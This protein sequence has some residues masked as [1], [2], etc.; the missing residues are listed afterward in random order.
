[1]CRSGVGGFR[2]TR[3]SRYHTLPELGGIMRRREFIAALCGATAMPLVARAQRPA[4]LQK[5]GFL[6]DES[7]SLG[8]AAAEL[9]AK[10]LH[11]LG[12][13]EGHNIAFESRYADGKNDAL[14]GLAAE[15]VRS[16]VN[17]MVA[18]GTPATR[19]A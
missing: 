9:I 5:V 4:A 14:A 12:Y 1:M 3:V 10:T 15:L 11:G 17:V 18:V 2:S 7:R 6:S 8:S 13:A 19:A 16:R